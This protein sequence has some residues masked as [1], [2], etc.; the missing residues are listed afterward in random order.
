MHWMDA[1]EEPTRWIDS[2]QNSGRK[3][4]AGS[5]ALPFFA[6]LRAP[7]PYFLEPDPLLIF[8]QFRAFANPLH[9]FAI[10]LA[11]LAELTQ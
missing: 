9:S 4:R 8:Q 11:R 5:P 2:D 6:W 3:G 7:P 10:H 1:D